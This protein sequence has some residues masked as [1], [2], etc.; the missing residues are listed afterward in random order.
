MHM[1]GYAALNL[2]YLYLNFATDSTAGAVSAMR[3]LGLR[4]LSLTIP[5][6]E[7]ALPLV[8]ELSPEAK[9]IGA[10]N[11]IVNREGRLFGENTDWIGVRD[12]FYEHGAD[13]LG[14]VVAGKSVLVL[15]AGG[16]ARAAI[17]AAQ[18]MNAASIAVWGRSTERVR[19]VCQ[20]FQVEP[21]QAGWDAFDVVINATPLGTDLQ[22]NRQSAVYPFPLELLHQH[23]AVLDMVT[24]ETPLFAA[25]QQ[26]GG[27][28]IA[29]TRMLLFQA[30]QQFELFT[31]HSAPREAMEQALAAA[32]LPHSAQR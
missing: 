7:R 18:Q 20:A 1:A 30:L 25:V 32:Y 26:V 23:Q 27:R 8:D 10:I 6:K 4:G 22:T 14:V 15:G 16:A 24:K 12:A 28:A 21:A 29:G 13:K 3:A 9:A 11:T 19:E 17:F 5:H 31:A 2:D